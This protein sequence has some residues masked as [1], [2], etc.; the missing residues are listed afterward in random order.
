[1][2][3]FLRIVAFL[4]ICQIGLAQDTLFLKN[5]EKSIVKVKEIGPSE[6]SFLKFDYLDG[7]IYRVNK[8]D[9]SKIF[10]SNGL[11]EYFNMDSTK[12]AF[13]QEVKEEKKDYSKFTFQDGQYDAMRYYK[14]YKGAGTASFIAGIF[15]LYGLPVPIATSLTKPRNAFYYAPDLKLYQNNQQ[16][17]S[18]FNKG[19]HRKKAGKA[20]ANYGLGAVTTVGLAFGLL[21][22]ALGAAFN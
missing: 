15:W 16:Y 17:A 6:I 8:S 22:I 19:A 12:I 5:N 7:P 3:D 4:L 10:F 11:K 9:V 21:I 18:G 2:K 13:Q 1:M 20:W 14:G